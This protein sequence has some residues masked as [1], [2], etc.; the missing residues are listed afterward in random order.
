M[1]CSNTRDSTVAKRGKNGKK[2]Y[3]LV[4]GCKID[5]RSAQVDSRKSGGLSY[6][7][8]QHF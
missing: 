8:V 6:Y 2:Q 7:I 4:T 5:V 3:V 1:W